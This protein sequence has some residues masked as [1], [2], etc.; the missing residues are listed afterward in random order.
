MRSEGFRRYTVTLAESAAGYRRW[1]S[2]GIGEDVR[3]HGIKD[4]LGGSLAVGSD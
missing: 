3:T 4:P 1:K 2:C